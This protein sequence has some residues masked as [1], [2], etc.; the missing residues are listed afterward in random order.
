MWS[1]VKPVIKLKVLVHSNREHFSRT[2]TSCVHQLNRCNSKRSS[3]DLQ[4]LVQKL[5]SFLVFDPTQMKA[6]ACY[7]WWLAAPRRS[8]WSGFFGACCGDCESPKEVLVTL[9]M[10]WA[11]PCRRWQ[12]ETPSEH[13]LSMWHGRWHNPLWVSQRGLGVIAKSSIPQEKILLPPLLSSIHFMS[14]AMFSV[15]CMLVLLA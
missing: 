3:V 6:R 9:Y 5:H 13:P 7:S 14:L 2:L 4:R 11:P 10:V 1:P 12:T 15:S 8:W